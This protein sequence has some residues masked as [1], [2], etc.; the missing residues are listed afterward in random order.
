MNRTL[1]LSLAVPLLSCT[2]LHAD[3]PAPG[4]QVELSHKVSDQQ[5][6]PYL[7][8]LP[9]DLD[10]KADKKWPV[11]L[12]LHGRG[13][14]RG[15]LSIVAKWGPPRMAERGDNLP[16]IVISPQCPASSR[17]TAD[18]QQAGVLNLLDH[19]SEK[20][21]VDTSRIYLTGL[22]MGGYGSWKLAADHGQR[23]AAVAPVCGK[24]NPADG[25][26][27]KDL[28]IWVFHGTE[29][30][31][32]AYQHSVDMVEAI[33]KAGGKKVRFTSMK[34]VGHNCWSA[35]YATPELYQWFDKHRRRD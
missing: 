27:L 18:E 1:S 34:H 8:Y 7:L 5:S 30:H 17:W 22:S 14:S 33:E 3:T 21:P 16:Y 32:V 19:I 11:I 28:P 31:A 6:V 4:K 10:A 13:E 26:K 23:F 9:K 25:E 12:F 35:A 29:D 2:T 15:P 20:Y 24:G